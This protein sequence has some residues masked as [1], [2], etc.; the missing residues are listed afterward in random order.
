MSGICGIVNLDGAPVDPEVLR[1]MAEAA[2]NR[3]PDGVGY[4]IQGHVGF[5]HLALDT[6]P[7]SL[8]E[9]QPLV[10]VDGQL[11]LAADA[12]VDNRDELIRT[13]TTRGY[14]QSKDPTDADLILAAYRCW[15]EEC[16]KHIVGDFAFA[17]WDASRRQLFCAR[18]PLG[19]RP[20]HYCRLDHR[21][22]MASSVG[23]VLAALDSFPPINEAL[24]QDLVAGQFGRWINE[25]AYQTIYRLPP[26]YCLVVRDGKIVLSRFWTLGAQPGIHYKQEAD[27]AAHFRQL[28]QDAVRARMRT[29]EPIAILL[30]GGLDSSSV[31]CLANH[32]ITSEGI[33]TPVRTYSCVFDHTPR[34]DE[35]EYLQAVLTECSHLQATLIGCDD[36][37]GMREFGADGGYPLVEP[38][39]GV[40]RM[41]LIKLLRR[42]RQDECR[43]V[44]GG[45]WGD[46]VLAGEAYLTSSLL[47]DVPAT[48]LLAELPHFVRQ[49]GHPIWWLLAAAYLRPVLPQGIVTWLKHW[50][51]RKKQDE[52]YLPLGQPSQTVA[53]DLLPPPTLKSRSA[54]Q[55]YRFLNEGINSARLIAYDTTAEYMG[56]EW[57]FPFLDRRLVEYLLA[58]PSTLFFR[59]GK[60]K[61]ILRQGM[62][63]VLPEKVRQRIHG[64]VFGELV[65]RGIGEQG[66]QRI[67]ELI[68]N[69]YIARAGFVDSE[70]LADRWA[71]YWQKMPYPPPRA[72]TWPL[73]A[74]AWLR[75]QVQQSMVEQGK[76]NSA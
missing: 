34:A 47:R 11:C 52:M 9:K 5:A 51:N 45:H 63:G 21:F 35:R 15:G 75:H 37:W 33:P 49:S 27:Y 59:E 56:V 38:E 36:C 14:L 2:A 64:A 43:I 74:E 48:D 25:T 57:R 4:W 19:V 46:Q 16:P 29:T 58:L 65:E 50:R 1:R 61:Y 20:L 54:R 55:I 42:I 24:I 32:L 8:R 13:L 23:A 3:G 39:M 26:A 72:V 67:Q 71:S 60:G 76:T 6:T 7:E 31:A 66:K 73:C 22:I 30:S 53:A 70:R 10:S 18:D 62:A 28:L 41:T 17:V 40:D 44:F 69:P 68:K 12:R